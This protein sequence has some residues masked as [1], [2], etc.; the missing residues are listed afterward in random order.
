[1]GDELVIIDFIDDISTTLLLFNSLLYPFV[2]L[3]RQ[4]S[5]SLTMSIPFP[6]RKAVL[7][8]FK[9]LLR[10][11]NPT[12]PVMNNRRAREHTLISSWAAEVGEYVPFQSSSNL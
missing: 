6:P 8:T 3:C 7:A 11:S 1:M 4:V 12:L 2:A 9:G 10:Y 5:S